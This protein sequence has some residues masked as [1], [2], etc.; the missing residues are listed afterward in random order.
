MRCKVSI[1]VVL[2]LLP[3]LSFPVFAA[4]EDDK[5][6]PVLSHIAIDRTSIAPGGSVVLSADAYDEDS[7]IKSITVYISHERS[8]VTY[9]VE[10]KRSADWDV[11]EEY[12]GAL[13]IPWDAETGEYLVQRI[14]L[15]DW[16]GN[17]AVYRRNGRDEALKLDDM[18]FT[19]SKAVPGMSVTDCYVDNTDRGPLVVLRAEGLSRGLDRARLTFENAEA[20]R[21]FYVTFSYENEYSDGSFQIRPDIS[22][23]V[24][25]GKY[26]LTR[27]TL[28]DKAGSLMVY[29]ISPDYDRG[30]MLL[31]PSPS[32]CIHT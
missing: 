11:D 10:L 24:S 7:R 31:V 4:R 18:R 22:N 5:E 1:I 20:Y 2:F 30:E 32:L 12:S 14:R 3:V 9:T 29:D 8:G 21:C 25:S 15:A 23:Y 26:S 6:P 16:N 17:T 27:L 19:V 28:R 13:I